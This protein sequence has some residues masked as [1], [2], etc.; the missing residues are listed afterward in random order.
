MLIPKSDCPCVCVCAWVF[1]D[2]RFSHFLIT[3]NFI[4]IIMMFPI[5]NGFTLSSKRRSAFRFMTKHSTFQSICNCLVWCSKNQL[6]VGSAT[7]RFSSHFQKTKSVPRTNSGNIFQTCNSFRESFL[8][9]APG[10][11]SPP[12]RCL[13]SFSP[14]FQSIED[15]AKYIVEEASSVMVMTGAGLSTASGIPDFR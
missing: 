3:D 11:N 4:Y 7:R 12:K 6:N 13:S 5:G 15:V 14:E 9:P 8:R 1:K 10:P 2:F